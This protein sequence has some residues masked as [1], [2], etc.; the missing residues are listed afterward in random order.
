MKVSCIIPTCNEHPQAAF[1]V[2]S[3]YCDLIQTVG[4]DGAPV[5]FEII[6][7]DNWSENTPGTVAPRDK[8]FEYFSSLAD[9]KRPWLKAFEYT[10]KLS[11]WNAKNLGVRNSDGDV[12]FFLDGHCVMSPGSLGKAL[13]Y[14]AMFKD[15]LD[16]TLHLPLSYMLDRPGKELIYKLKVDHGTGLYHYAFTKYKADLVP[17]QVPCMSTCGMLMSRELYDLLGGWPEELGIYG[18]G[19]NFVNFTLAVLGKTVNIFPTNPLYHYAA[20][21]GYSWQYDDFHRNRTI[22]SYM[23]GG[24]ELAKLYLKNIRGATEQKEA[25]WSTIEGVES[26]VRQREAI[27]ANQVTTIREW[28]DLWNGST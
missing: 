14:H 2:Q 23:Y 27:A 26:I 25:I 8:G 11:H 15:E 13:R 7:I 24:D 19:E 17:Y 6:V 1:T 20:P 28:A 12:L 9:G 4:L 5:D 16:G 18:G 21:R 3:L 10:D 22:A